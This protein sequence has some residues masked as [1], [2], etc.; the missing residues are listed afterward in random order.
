[1]KKCKCGFCNEKFKSLKDK[2]KHREEYPNG[3]CK[4]IDQQEDK[5]E[6]E[7]KKLRKS[8]IQKITKILIPKEQA[9]VEWKK[10]CKLLKKRKDE[11]LKILRASMYFAK[12][13]KSLINVYEAI[14]KAGLNS[15][16][17]PRLAIARADIKEVHFNKQDTG[18]GSFCMEDGWNRRGWN[19]DVNLPQK[20]FKINWE[21]LLKNDGTP[22]WEIK[23]KKIV[24]K[25][26]IIPVDLMPEG[27]LKNYYILWEV[28]EWQQLP[29]PKDPFLLKRISENMFVILGTW[30]ITELERAII[31]GLK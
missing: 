6:T 11:H 24:T 3:S 9:K 29:Q 28:K 7:K 27:K 2:K 18:S 23:D 12:Q 22:S 25:V 4:K 19:T 13:G 20:A 15:K 17:E 31:N 30:D 26:P 10:Y 14:K 21:R 16:K 1:M 5:Q 8:P